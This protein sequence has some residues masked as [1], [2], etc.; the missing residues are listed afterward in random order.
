MSRSNHGNLSG[1]GDAPPP[2]PD[3]NMAQLLRLLME[4][5]QAARD[6]RQANMAALQQLVQAATNANQGG[7]G[8]GANEEPRS[9]LQDFQNTNPLVFSQMKEPLDAED[10]LRTMEN[11]LAVAAIGDNEKVLYATHYL[12]DTARSWW[13]GV[14]A[15]LPEGQ[16][17]SWAEFSD[18][19]KKAH[20]STA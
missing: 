4:E 5:R 17:L 15:R 1:F 13:E 18:K 8:A 2:P 20:I 16:V 11:N 14:R 9:R 12:T 3:P 10:W 7:G 6:V 19:F